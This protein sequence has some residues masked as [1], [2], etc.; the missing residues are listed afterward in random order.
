MIENSPQPTPTKL[1]VSIL[2]RIVPMIA[3]ALP[4]IGGGATAFFL[5]QVFS[6]LQ[7]A[8]SAGVAAGAGGTAE[9]NV[10][11]LTGLYLG[12][13]VGF[14]AL[15]TAVLRMFTAKKRASPPGVFYLLP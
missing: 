1:R 8:E 6:A 7:N 13:L 4:V 5:Q 15:G 12:I 10:A 9:A 11:V 3:F 2:E 14:V